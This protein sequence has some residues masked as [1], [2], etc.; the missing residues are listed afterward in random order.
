MHVQ[1]LGA[2]YRRETGDSFDRGNTVCVCVC[3]AER[4]NVTLGKFE[5]IMEYVNIVLCI[6][7]ICRVQLKDLTLYEDVGREE[8]L[9]VNLCG[10]F[11]LIARALVFIFV[12][13]NKC[14]G[15]L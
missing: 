7:K 8:I 5:R 3:V 6:R 11:F 9:L 1:L 10:F 4:M 13:D 2:N 15:I 14:F 12:L